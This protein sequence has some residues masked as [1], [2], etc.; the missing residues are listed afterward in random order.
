MFARK[1]LNES[2]S[3]ALFVGAL[4]A[5][6]CVAGCGG[7]TSS[8]SPSNNPQDNVPPTVSI[9]APAAGSTQTGTVNLTAT[10]SDNIGVVGVQFLIDGVATGSEQTTAPYR[11]AWNSASVSNGS[12][13]ITA[14]A[15]DAAGNSTVS[16]AVTV[17]V[18]NTNPVDSTPPT[19]SVTAPANSS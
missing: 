15:R 11:S 17:T 19:V 8:G 4:A 9:T 6:L 10:A 5:A 7:T 2:C 3:S 13:S 12:H 16:S 18:S 1:E 14:K